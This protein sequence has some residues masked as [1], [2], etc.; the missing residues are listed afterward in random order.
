[1]YTKMAAPGRQ[2]GD[3][4]ASLGKLCAELEKRFGPADSATWLRGPGLGLC[5]RFGEV[6]ATVAQ[7]VKIDNDLYIT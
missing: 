3:D 2:P 7:P 5:E 6:R 4:I 1:M